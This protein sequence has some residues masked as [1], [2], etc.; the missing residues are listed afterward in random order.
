MKPAV[1]GGIVIENL[2]TRSGLRR[3]IEQYGIQTR[4][5]LGQHFLVDT[6]VVEKI[7][8]AADLSAADCVLEIGPGPGG[9]TQALS[10]HAGHIVVVEL[11][12]QLIPVL[13]SLFPGPNITI[14]QG[15]ILKINLPEILA[16]HAARP[17]KVVANLPY[18]ITTP[19]IIYLLESGLPFKSITVMVQ[20]EVAR[21][22]AASPGTKD[23][24]SL[25]LAIKYH[26]DV[27][28][29][30]NV[31][32][33]SFMPRPAVDSA[34]VQLHPRPQ[35]PV[36]AD[37]TQLFKIIHAAFNQRR[38]TLVN[39]LAAGLEMDKAIIVNTLAECGLKPDVR[40]ETLDMA[41][42]AQIAAVLKM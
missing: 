22:M 13:E 16:P 27:D 40:G 31:P 28:L 39:A 17:V 18:Y 20:K 36:T 15:D 4:K 23:Y 24:G 10:A 34:V 11:D 41:A 29:V 19:V 1:L 6:H 8:S 35:P 7:I 38:K 30:A 9:L 12:K 25:T 33:N 14:I 3:I 2:S 42:F 32:V 37:K 5:K 26:A 21:R